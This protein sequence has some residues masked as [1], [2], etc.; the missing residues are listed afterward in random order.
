MQVPSTE[1]LGR[2]FHFSFPNGAAPRVIV[3]APQVLKLSIHH[4][5][6][7]CPGSASSLSGALCGTIM[8]TTHLE[9]RGLTN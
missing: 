3:L 5:Q 4:F 1:T 2:K 8:V 7:Y 9:K 6:C